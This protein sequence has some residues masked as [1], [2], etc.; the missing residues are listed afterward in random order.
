[1]AGHEMHTEYM[2]VNIEAIRKI[3]ENLGKIAAVG[4]T[5]LRTLESLYWL[6]VKIYQN[7]KAD[8]PEVLQ[9]D[10]YDSGI[11]NSGLAAEKAL[12]TLIDFLTSKNK[13]S[14]FTRTQI[15]IVPGY[16]FRIV[17]MLVTNFHQP[18]STLL[19]LVAAAIG[20]DWK[21][22]YAYALEN[23]FRFLSYGD[24]NLIFIKNQI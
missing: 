8:E 7:K 20:D 12:Q 18:S 16:R 17:N 4:T 23:N 3:K 6:G 24:G 13:K 10:A 19:L 11:G 14:I 5:S 21:R 9:W 22:M 15:L 2:E 1:M